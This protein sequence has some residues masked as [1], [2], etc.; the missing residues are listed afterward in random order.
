M[1]SQRSVLYSTELCCTVLYCSAPFGFALDQ[2][3]TNKSGTATF[4]DLE[5]RRFRHN[6]IQRS[7]SRRLHEGRCSRLFLTMEVGMF[8]PSRLDVLYVGELCV[9]AWDHQFLRTVLYC[10][11][12][13][14]S[15][16][17]SAVRRVRR[18]GGRPTVR[19]V[20]RTVDRYRPKGSLPKPNTSIK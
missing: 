4:F 20:C 16:V 13:G 1:T 11:R 18:P 12:V 8:R 7:F 14:E 2:A 17:R 5:T 19:T 3:A 9:A 6:A 10:K 15:S